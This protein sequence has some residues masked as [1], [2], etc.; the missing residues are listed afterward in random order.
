MR[1]S[2]QI[3]LLLISVGLS[4]CGW[5]G[6][7]ER[8]N[9][10]RN[11]GATGEVFKPKVKNGLL[12]R[13]ASYNIRY[14]TVADEKTGNGWAI[15]KQP[16]ADLIRRH[17]LNVVGTQEGN[18]KQMDELMELLPEYDYIGYPYAGKTSMDH[19]ASIVYKKAQYEVVDHGVFWYSETPD[20]AS[21]GWDA[22]DMRIC[23]WAR[24]KHKTS[25]REF[26]FFTSHFYWR[27]VTA[28]RNSGAVMVQKIKEIVKDDLPVISTG[29]LN[30]NPSTAQIKEVKDLLGDAYDLTETPRS[31]PTGTGFPGGVFEGNPGSR[32]D[33]VFVNDKIQVL[34]YAV[35]TDKYGELGRYPSDHLPV[36]CDLLLKK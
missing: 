32:I 24:M 8:S 18:F 7:A 6:G 14:A 5:I 31:G 23:T 19:T 20:T 12:V 16:L 22:T 1:K 13:I 35:L 21:I 2:I 17:G 34:T 29:D 11:T 28:K 36:V 33:Y 3:F 9:D 4:S 30:S 26:Y 25:K 15:R 10:S 27:Y